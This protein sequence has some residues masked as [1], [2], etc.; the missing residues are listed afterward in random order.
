MESLTPNVSDT[1]SVRTATVLTTQIDGR[2]AGIRFA[3]S[4]RHAASA[5]LNPDGSARVGVQGDDSD[6]VTCMNFPS[7]ESLLSIDGGS[8]PAWESLGALKALNAALTV[9]REIV[10]RGCRSSSDGSITDPAICY[11]YTGERRWR[12]V[13][14]GNLCEMSVDELVSDLMAGYRTRS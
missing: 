5:D 14:T 10:R 12:S 3:D 1:V 4:D 11:P 2:E 9:L 13:P 6:L 8:V 7:H